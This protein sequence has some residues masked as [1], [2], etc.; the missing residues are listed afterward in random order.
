MLFLWSEIAK[1][2]TNNSTYW[3]SRYIKVALNHIFVVNVL[4]DK[5]WRKFGYTMVMLRKNHP[6]NLFQRNNYA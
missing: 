6:R 3:S 1:S 4:L 2:F 5:F